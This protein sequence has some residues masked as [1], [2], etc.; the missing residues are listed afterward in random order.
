MN[1]FDDKLLHAV[2]GLVHRSPTVDQ[3]MVFLNDSDLLAGH[4]I[5][6]AFWWGWFL[7][8]DQERHR[9]VIVST[10]VAGMA[11][12]L[13][14]RLMA[15]LLPFRVRPLHAGSF[16]LVLPYG[17]HPR[18]LHG[19]SSFPSDHAMMFYTLAFGML[20]ISR[21]A[22]WL[23]LLYVTFVEG[24]ARVYVLLH[25]PSDIAGGLVVAAAA[26]W[27]FTRPALRDRIARPAFAWLAASP[28]TFYG[29]AAFLTFQIATMFDDLRTLIGTFFNLPT[30]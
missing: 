12:L 22:G 3:F 21:P 27:V 30:A 14:G 9:A 26:A 19:W 17:M 16:G 2:N 15:L 7:R 29:V 10:F 25:Y 13:A 23:M 18:L 4:V 1:P 11:A 24:F 6:A 20:A 8:R 28:A 5:L